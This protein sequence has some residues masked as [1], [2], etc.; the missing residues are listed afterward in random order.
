M[1]VR[2]LPDY[3]N[4]IERLFQLNLALFFLR[5][6][7]LQLSKRLLRLGYHFKGEPSLHGI[8]YSRIGLLMLIQAIGEFVRFSINLF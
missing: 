4:I 5:G 2:N 3:H 1:F 8:E 7:W 6:Y